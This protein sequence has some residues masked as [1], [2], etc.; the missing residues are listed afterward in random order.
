[1]TDPLSI[2]ASVITLIGTADAIVKSLQKVRNLRKAP[3]EVLALYNELTDLRVV[4]DD[5]SSCLSEVGDTSSSA[6][7]RLRH[8]ASLIDR[9]KEH[10][11]RLDETMHGRILKS[12]SL[13]GEFKVSRTQWMKA[14]APAEAIRQDLREVRL[15]IMAQMMTI[16]AYI[17][18]CEHL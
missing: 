17:K 12:G 8:M 14:K 11:Q 18:C 10:M 7:K 4:L 13:D 9:A 16:N 15:N 3:G 6:T 2:A 1:M 5:V